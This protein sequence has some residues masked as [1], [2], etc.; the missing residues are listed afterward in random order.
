MNQAEM[1]Q[2][3]TKIQSDMAMLKME[4]EKASLYAAQSAAF[5]DMSKWMAKSDKIKQ[6]L[7]EMKL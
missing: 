3:F 6:G 4:V 5:R 7:V 2:R 1:L